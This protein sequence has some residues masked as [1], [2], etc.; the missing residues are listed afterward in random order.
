MAKITMDEMEVINEINPTACAELF[1][2]AYEM[3]ANPKDMRGPIQKT[4]HEAELDYTPQV[5]AK[6]VEFMT[7]TECYIHYSESGMVTF[8]ALGYRMGP[9][10]DR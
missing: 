3:V 10:G 1:R 4:M 6:A 2:R 8:S 5:V 9:A 7:A